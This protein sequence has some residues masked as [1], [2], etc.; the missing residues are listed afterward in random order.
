M[1][2][3]LHVEPDMNVLEIGTGTGYST[4]LLTRRLGEDQVTSIEYDA[5]VA[6]RARNSL[7]RLDLQPTLLTGDG[8]RGAPESGPYDRII[9]TC[10]V[11]TVPGVDRAD[12]A[13]RHHPHHHRRLAQR[14]RTRAPDRARGRNGQRTRARR[15]RQLHA[16][17]PPHAAAARCPRTSPT[18]ASARRASERTL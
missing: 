11:R 8:L 10:A 7:S 3:D 5:V 4:A 13:R 12:P 6:Q 17:T 16:G 18:D 15:T 1:L 9:A 14:V 2:E